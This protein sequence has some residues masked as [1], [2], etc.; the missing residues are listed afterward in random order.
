MSQPLEP[1]P[2]FVPNG[3]EDVDELD[4]IDDAL[5]TDNQEFPEKAADNFPEGYPRDL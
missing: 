5:E 1:T 2:G 3:D 4:E